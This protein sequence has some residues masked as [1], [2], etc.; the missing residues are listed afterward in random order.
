MQDYT[1]ACEQAVWFD[2]SLRGKIDLTGPDARVF[3]HNLCTNNVKDMAAGDGCEAFLCT[4]KAR[5]VAH[6][7]VG[8]Y[9]AGDANVIRLD[10]EPGCAET[11]FNHL[12]HYLISE[13]VELADRTADFALLRLCGSQAHTILSRLVGTTLPEMPAWHHSVCQLRGDGGELFARRQRFLSVPGF[14][15][16]CA[17]QTVSQLTE[18]LQASGATVGKPELHEVLRIEAG[19][20]VFG[21]DT[22]ANRLVME[23]GRIE[24]A[25]SYTKGCFLGQEPIV[26]ARD[27]GHVN[28]LLLGVK[29]AGD[30]VLPSGARLFRDAEEVGQVTSSAYSPRLGH[31][32]A[33]AYL[34][35]GNWEPGTGVTVEPE[36]DGRS[37]E[38]AALPFVSSG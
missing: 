36:S 25:I 5:V 12:N 11:V 26:M 17:T 3:L 9:R 10:V 1:R 14:D 23:V 19:S 28:R 21:P 4:N 20:P 15:L 27:R 7:L 2:L 38:V 16:L 8:C 29:V 37:A 31:V 34:R 22:D 13:R 6:I 32:V 30:T 24:Q 35:R 33:L 18:R